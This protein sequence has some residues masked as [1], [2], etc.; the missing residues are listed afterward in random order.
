MET[1]LY[2]KVINNVLDNVKEAKYN[3]PEDFMQFS[4]YVRVV[5]ELDWNSSPGYPYMLNYANNRDFFRVNML[6]EP[7]MQRVGE[8]WL[9]VKERLEERNSDPIRLF[10]K[11]E[12]ISNKKLEQGRFRLI[13]SVS[14]IDQIIDSMVFG[15]CCDKFVEKCHETP[16]KTGW[17][18]LLGGWKE[19]PMKGVSTDKSSWDWTV[20]AWLVDCL[21]HVLYELM[22]IKNLEWVD[23]AKYRFQQLFY[24]PVFVTSGGILLKQEL[25]GVMK[26]GCKLTILGNSLMQLILHHRVAEEV[27]E[28]LGYV[29]AMGDDVIQSNQSKEYFQ[30][31]SEY[32]ILKEVTSR[33][34]FSGYRFDSHVEPLYLGKHGYMLLHQ[35]QQY[36]AETADAYALLYHRS[37]YVDKIRGYLQ[38]ITEKLVDKEMLTEL[39]DNE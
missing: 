32:C 1:H 20:N 24:E 26:S 13:S 21:L 22:E 37:R 15:V 38:Q 18:P 30:R 17:T 12:P 28:T 3:L 4:H 2:R 9:L 23:L 8:I 34:E 7:N 5:K 14:I 33:I 35:D 16:V 6:G 29:W 31:L 36:H 25:P 19:I 27:G 39:W 11:P 10:I